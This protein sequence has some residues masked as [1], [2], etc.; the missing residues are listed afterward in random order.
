MVVKS[1]NPLALTLH[2]RVDHRVARRLAEDG[3]HLDVPQG[4]EHQLDH[5]RDAF[6]RG[7]LAGLTAHFLQQRHILI[8]VVV[9]IP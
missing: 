2:L 1:E 8:P 3:I 7:G 4:A 5:L 6:S 9:D